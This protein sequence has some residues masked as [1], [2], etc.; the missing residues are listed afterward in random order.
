M[1]RAFYNTNPESIH[2]LGNAGVERFHEGL[3]L[4][5]EREYLGGVYLIGL[6][7]EILLKYACLSFIS[8]N[9]HPALPHIDLAD[10]AHVRV[11]QSKHWFRHFPMPSVDHHSLA[12][13]HL[14]LRDLRLSAGKSH[15]VFP[16]QI[17][18]IQ[19]LHDNWINDMRYMPNP[20]IESDA[21][22]FYHASALVYSHRMELGK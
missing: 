21:Q 3:Q 9:P 12:Y 4:L 8:T 16:E 20:L 11:K 17:A 14:L 1:F 19:Y 5:L 15:I 7:M 10:D 13:W 22:T 2:D 18:V 6:S